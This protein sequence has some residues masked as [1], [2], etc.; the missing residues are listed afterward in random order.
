VVVCPGS[1]GLHLS[2][3]HFSKFAIDSLYLSKLLLSAL[4][5]SKVISIETEQRTYLSTSFF[6]F[7]FL[8]CLCIGLQQKQKQL[9]LEWFLPHC[10]VL[11][12]SPWW[13][14]TD[15]IIAW[16]KENRDPQKQCFKS[17]QAKHRREN[18]R[19]SIYSIKWNTEVLMMAHIYGKEKRT[20][21]SREE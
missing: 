11:C 7:F 9:E 19:L 17:I 2:C 10:E 6:F 14:C 12:A 3:N 4:I 18:S 8:L 5:T 1:S 16:N 21:V 15:L 20:P 13:V